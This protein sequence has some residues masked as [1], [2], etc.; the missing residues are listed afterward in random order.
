[1]RKKY[2]K[3]MQ[4]MKIVEIVQFYAI[5]YKKYKEIYR[6]INNICN[7]ICEVESM[8]VERKTLTQLSVPDMSG[9]FILYAFRYG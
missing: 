3:C 9:N 4:Q 2:G 5:L 7:F 1:M 6:I 8:A